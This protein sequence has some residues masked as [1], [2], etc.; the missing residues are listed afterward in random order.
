MTTAPKIEPGI[1]VGEVCAR[2][3]CVGIIAEH[4]HDTGCSCHINPPCGH[5]TTP[6]EYCP[7]CDWDALEEQARDDRIAHVK[8]QEG[9]IHL[10]TNGL[11]HVE[12]KP[13]VLDRT[14]I[15]YVI[16]MH[17]GSSQKV[18]GVYPE[19]TTQEEVRKLV[20]GTFGGRFERFGHGSFC[21][22][23]YTD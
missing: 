2:F 7:V 21:F 13:R 9:A 16:S 4:D 1:E 23:A 22:I 10:G 11:M 6:R 12:R 3:G 8:W 5:C 18:E 20:N 14:K 17:S 15:D 19:G